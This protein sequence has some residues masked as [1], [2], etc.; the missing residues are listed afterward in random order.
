[1]SSP[2]DHILMVEFLLNE[3]IENNQEIIGDVIRD[4]NFY[5][6]EKREKEAWV[7]AHYDCSTASNLYS[8]VHWTYYPHGR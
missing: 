1:M 4:L 2:V 5:L 8:K 3:T 7:Y 6:G